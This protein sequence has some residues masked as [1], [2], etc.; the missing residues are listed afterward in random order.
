ML[1]ANRRLHSLRI[2]PSRQLVPRKKRQ[3]GFAV[4]YGVP[5]VTNE[6]TLRAVAYV[7]T[8]EKKRGYGRCR[9]CKEFVIGRSAV[10]VRSSAPVFKHLALAFTVGTK[11]QNL[12]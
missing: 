10:Q 9:P 4:L 12:A 5:K 11:V 6:V 2:G 8:I 7:S 1:S 3:N